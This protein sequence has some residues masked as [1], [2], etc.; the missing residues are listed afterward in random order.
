[1]G[2]PEV[3]AACGAISG[4][5]L[6]T[7]VPV[8]P[9]RAFEYAILAIVVSAVGGMGSMTGSVLGGL[10]VGVIVSICQSM[11]YGSLAQAI[12]YAMVFLI[13][14]FRPTGIVKAQWQ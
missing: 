9:D 7:L 2:S 13:F 6:A 1:M 11:G 14:L 5:A 4:V 12:V 8:Y 3:G 10:L